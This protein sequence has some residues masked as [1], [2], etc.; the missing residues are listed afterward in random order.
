MGRVTP[1]GLAG[2]DIPLLA[3]IIAVADA[4]HAMISKR[5]YREALPVALAVLELKAGAGRSGIPPSS[6]RCSRSWNRTGFG[7]TLR[8]ARG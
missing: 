2:D 8:A 3:R 4:F 5:P 1:I 7:R 6:P